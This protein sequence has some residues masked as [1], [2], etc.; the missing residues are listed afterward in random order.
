MAQVLH[1][2]SHPTEKAAEEAATDY[3]R[4]WAPEG[5]GTTTT[6][7]PLSNGTWIMSAHRFDCC[8]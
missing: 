7:T 4:Q 8:D 5:Y 1:R 2:T 6:V 3:K